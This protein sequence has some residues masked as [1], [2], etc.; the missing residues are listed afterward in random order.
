[1]A[2]VVHA[3]DAVGHAGLDPQLVAVCR[4]GVHPYPPGGDAGQASK[5]LPRASSICYKSVMTRV[6]LI[7]A[8]MASPA[9]ATSPIA[10]VICEPTEVMHQKLT[11]QFGETRAAT[12]LRGREQIMEV[13]TDKQGDWTMV[14]TYASGTSC[15][16]AMGE[17]WTPVT[18]PDPA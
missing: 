12:G 9:L 3:D 16:V 15:I 14:V 6:F 11:R 5:P 18:P 8:C 7:L 4:L 2:G 13:W 1:M 17:E 10:H